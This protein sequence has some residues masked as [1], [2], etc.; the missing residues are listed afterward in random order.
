[1]QSNRREFIRKSVL[2]SGAAGLSISPAFSESSLFNYNG[3]RLVL[4]G[5]QGG[6]LIRSSKQTPSANLIVYKDVHFVIDTGYGATFRLKEAGINL[7]ALKYIFITHLHPT[8]ILTWAHYY[9]MPGFLVYLNK[10]IFMHQQGSG[11]L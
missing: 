11:R 1:M 6:P 4:L 3:D 7:A 2:L 5:P 10:F 8:I 9:T